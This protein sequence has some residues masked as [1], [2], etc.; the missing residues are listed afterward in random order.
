MITLWYTKSRYNVP[1]VQTCFI[2]SDISIAD[3]LCFDYKYVHFNY[4][5][6]FLCQVAW[7]S[8]NAK[9][10]AWNTEGMRIYF[11]NNIDVLLLIIHTQERVAITWLFASLQLTSHWAGKPHPLLLGDKNAEGMRT[12]FA[13]DFNTLIISST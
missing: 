2:Y 9:G 10:N 7:K 8:C 11:M 13:D 3:F 12:F 6:Q 5:S 4:F 1:T